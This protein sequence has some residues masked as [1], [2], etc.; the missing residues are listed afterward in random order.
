MGVGVRRV[1]RLRAMRVAVHRVGIRAMGVVG[2]QVTREADHGVAT[3]RAAPAAV[4]PAWS[5]AAAVGHRAADRKA[6]EAVVRRAAASRA[7]EIVPQA[8]IKA[9][10]KAVVLKA[11]VLKAAVAAEHGL[12]EA[13][14]TIDN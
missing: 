6:A 10:P 14:A 12:Q 8:V 4:L 2:L 7:A 9:G 1:E 3:R 5:R 13:A 11:V